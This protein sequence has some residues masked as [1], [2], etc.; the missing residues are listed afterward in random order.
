M[1]LAYIPIATSNNGVLI[2]RNIPVAVNAEK[3]F[4]DGVK[5]V[6]LSRLTVTISTGKVFYADP[7]SR[8]DIGDAIKLSEILGNTETQ[9]KLAEEYDGQKVAIVTLNEL[10]EALMLGLQTKASLIGVIE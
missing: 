10:Q 1:E 4:N 9:W 8:S 7:I 2:K 3:R 5:E 6:S